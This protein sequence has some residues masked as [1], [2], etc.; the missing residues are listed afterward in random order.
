MK[1]IE[2]TTEA[3]RIKDFLSLPKR[4]YK[5]EENTEDPKQTKAILLGKHP[6]SKYSQA[7]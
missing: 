2:F 1:C 4:L 7:E 3:K 5:P 6:L